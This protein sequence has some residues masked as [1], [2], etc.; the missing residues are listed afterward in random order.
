MTINNYGDAYQANS[1]HGIDIAS[2]RIDDLDLQCLQY[3][4]ELASSG[5]PRVLDFGAGRCG[6]SNRVAQE[7]PAAEVIAVDL[8]DHRQ[9]AVAGVTFVQ[10]E[11]TEYLSSQD[12]T[13][14]DIAYSQRT[15]HYLPYEAAKE[16]LQTLQKKVQNGGRLYLS[17]SGLYSELSEGYADADKPVTAR[18]SRLSSAM[19]LTHNICEPV[20]LY[21]EDDLRELCQSSGWIVL[22]T[23]RSEF[24]NCK[25]IAM[26]R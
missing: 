6:F 19:S 5:N 26:N 11:I 20:C 23:W 25:L 17:A 15:I 10:S 24:G 12:G 21:T 7:V 14:F 16:S 2:Q 1:S 4:Q 8:S 18:F 13:F 22:K 3:I 9:H